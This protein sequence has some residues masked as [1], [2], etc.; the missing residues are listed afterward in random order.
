MPTLNGHISKTKTFQE[1]PL[2]LL[3]RAQNHLVWARSYNSRARD[4]VA[5]I[6]ISFSKKL[7]ISGKKGVNASIYTRKEA[8]FD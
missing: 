5:N 1:I 8:Y 4:V 2:V 7:Q 6:L 3:E